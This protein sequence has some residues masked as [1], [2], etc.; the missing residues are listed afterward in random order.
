MR[1]DKVVCLKYVG[2]RSQRCDRENQEWRW[3]QIKPIYTWYLELAVRR[4]RC[5]NCLL[6]MLDLLTRSLSEIKSY[7]VVLSFYIK[8]MKKRTSQACSLKYSI[9]KDMFS[10][11]SKLNLFK[12]S[13]RETSPPFPPPPP[14]PPLGHS[15]FESPT[16]SPKN[17]SLKYFIFILN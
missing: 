7:V 14:L 3:R 2:E 12:S 11:W 4:L 15:K 1:L 9:K 5:I 10:V 8:I 13:R 6:L 16:K 17:I